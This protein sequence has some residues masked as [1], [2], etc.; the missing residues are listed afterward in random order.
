ME[1]EGRCC[2]PSLLYECND[3]ERRFLENPVGMCSFFIHQPKQ[4][5]GQSHNL[6]PLSC[7]WRF[8]FSPSIPPWDEESLLRMCNRAG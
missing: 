3:C 4:K 6:P 2:F 1:K 8:V 7:L 5:E